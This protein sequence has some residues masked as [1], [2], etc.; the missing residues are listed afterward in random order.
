MNLR[1][2]FDFDALEGLVGAESLAAPIIGAELRYRGKW[3]ICSDFTFSHK[4]LRVLPYEK[5]GAHRIKAV[6]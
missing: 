1:W 2:C 4:I 6:F 5:I 3:L